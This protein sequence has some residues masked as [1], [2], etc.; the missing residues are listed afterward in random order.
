M[1]VERTEYYHAV[2]QLSRKIVDATYMQSNY[3]SIEGSEESGE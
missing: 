1:I 2:W 3:N